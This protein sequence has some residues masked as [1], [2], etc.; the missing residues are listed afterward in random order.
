MDGRARRDQI[1]KYSKFPAIYHDQE[2][3]TGS[4]L[5]FNEAP[6]SMRRGLEAGLCLSRLDFALKTFDTKDAGEVE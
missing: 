6:P 1:L 3:T 5:H 2:N 4:K